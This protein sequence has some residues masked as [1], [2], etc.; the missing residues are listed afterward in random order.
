MRCR[1]LP[2]FIIAILLSFNF[3]FAQRPYKL[4]F[5]KEAFITSGGALSSIAALMIDSKVKPLS[6]EEINKLSSN[7]LSWIDKSA[8]FNW[9]KEFSFASDI[10]V[11]LSAIAP[12]LLFISK[13]TGKD[14]FI[15]SAMYLETMIYSFALP[16]LAKGSI[17]RTRPYVYNSETPLEEKLSTDAN[18]S[19]FSG[20]TTVAFSSAVFLSTLYGDYFPGSKF[21]PYVWAGT[22]LVAAITGY[23]RYEAGKHF[24]TDIITGAIVG[25][26]IGYLIP[27]IHRQSSDQVNMHKESPKQTIGI[28]FTYRF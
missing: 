3:S 26:A 25:S 28:S 21:K 12:A 15:I 10:L 17:Q 27:F 5:T 20:H 1:N 19:F 14:F 8:A 4:D 22:L 24:P 16:Y 11:S 7:N 6:F 18:T 2:L 9:S 13:R 23:T